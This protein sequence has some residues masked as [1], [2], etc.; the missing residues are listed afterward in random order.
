MSDESFE[1]SLT[2]L[3]PKSREKRILERSLALEDYK[4]SGGK[5]SMRLYTEE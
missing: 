3:S 4:N 5:K 2:G 1:R